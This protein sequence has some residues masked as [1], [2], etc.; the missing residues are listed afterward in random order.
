MGRT[1]SDHDIVVALIT[2][3]ERLGGVPTAKEYCAL[4]RE[5]E[6]PSLATVLNRMGGWRNAVCVAGLVPAST[7]ARTRSRRWTAETCL[8]AV[9]QVVVELGEI[10]TVVGYDRHVAGRVDLPS[11]ATVRNRLGRWSAVTARLA[12]GR[13]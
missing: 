7:P 9:R 11:S 2:V 1:Y 10:P 8:D 4:A 3:A 12:G 5:L 6:C 13:E